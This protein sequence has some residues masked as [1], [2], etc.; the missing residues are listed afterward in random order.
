MESESTTARVTGDTGLLGPFAPFSGRV[1]V[2]TG[3]GSGT[4]IGFAVATALAAHG[5]RVFLTSTTARCQDRAAELVALGFDA[6]A[7]PA[8]LTATSD[9][10][11]LLKAVR[12]R[13]GPVEILVNNAGMTSVLDPM[14]DGLRTHELTDVRWAHTVERNLNVCFHITAKVLVDMLSAQWGRIVSVAST[15]GVTGAMLGESAYAAAK[16]GVVGFTKTVA[17]EYAGDGIT[18]NAVAP[19]WIATASQTTD[20]MRQGRA[21]PIGRSGTAAEVAHVVTMLCL[22]SAAYVTGQCIVVDGGN[23]IAEERAAL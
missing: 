4:G 19:G 13:Y 8:D 9:V 17:L 6:A 20:E 10:D 11:A 14:E 16:A 5:S 2:V 7:F 23:S 21:T 18:A 1:A 12:A 3:A 15:T 22:P